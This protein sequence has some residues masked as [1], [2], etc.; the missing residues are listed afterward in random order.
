MY[1][2]IIL[3]YYVI[4]YG[5]GD[6]M[7]KKPDG[8]QDIIDHPRPFLITSLLVFLLFMIMNFSAIVD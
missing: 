1:Y 8:L 3:E 2:G 5:P 6:Q 7:R 4:E